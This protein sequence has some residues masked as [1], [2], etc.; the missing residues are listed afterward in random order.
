[1]FGNYRPVNIKQLPDCFLSQP[2]ITILNPNF[3][4]VGT[5]AICFCEYEKI[6]GAVTDLNFFIHRKQPLYILFLLL[7]IVFVISW[8]NYQKIQAIFQLFKR[9]TV[10]LHKFFTNN[11][12]IKVLLIPE[13]F[14]KT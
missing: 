8:T 13:F 12:L 3:N 1:M 7:K 2:Y 11:K 4:G 9:K 6:S 5:T 10:L 14:L